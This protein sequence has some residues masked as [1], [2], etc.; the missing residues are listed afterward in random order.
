[1]REGKTPIKF[2]RDY[3]LLGDD[4]VIFNKKV[5]DEYQFLIQEV[6]GIAINQSKSVIGSSKLSQ[7]EFTKRLAL[8]GKE[9]SSIKRNILTK[10]SMQNMLDLVD[11]L[12]E[13]D[14]IPTD[15]YNY[16][17]YHFL[18]S[19]DQIFFNFMLWV[20]SNSQAPFIQG[21]TSPCWIDRYSFNKKLLEYRSQAIMEKVNASLFNTK[22][23]LREY[24]EEFSVP[25][26]SKALGPNEVIDPLRFYPIV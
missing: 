12:H 9:M 21:I 17:M 23:N 18:G 15:T 4:I 8:E 16:S 11:I 1:V 3:R 22:G 6:Y 24:F 13:R 2:F 25:C 7:I 20:R 5:A 10:N 26:S 19:K 14:F